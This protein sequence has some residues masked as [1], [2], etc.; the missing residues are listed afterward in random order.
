MKKHF[1]LRIFFVVVVLSQVSCFDYEDKSR[2][3]EFIDGLNFRPL[4]SPWTA[5]PR[6]SVANPTVPISFE[7]SSLTLSSIASVEIY[8]SY[9]PN[10]NMP[11]G[12]L[13]VNTTFANA[14][15]AVSGTQAIPEVPDSGRNPV[16]INYDRY[17]QLIKGVTRAT[18]TTPSVTF[19]PVPRVLVKKLNAA[20][21]LG[22][23]SFT[24]AE[25]V[26]ATGATLP[27]A[28][29]A[30]ISQQPTFL[31]TFEV[32]NKNGQVFSYRN[33][34]PGINGNPPTGRVA[35]RT[36]VNPTSGGANKNYEIILS[37]NEGS[38]FVPGASV[39]VG[40]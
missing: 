22:I 27:G 38:E 39:R 18:A 21:V 6:L 16:T 20:D 37:G 32:T 23:H 19:T 9:M 25:L 33:G 11:A 12:V 15:G 10:V 5:R 4:P 3:P 17:D 35:V 30:T 13:A 28:I 31:F 14:V 29:S 8:A 40:P 34:S 24:L 7:I 26:A 2:F 36:W 1:F